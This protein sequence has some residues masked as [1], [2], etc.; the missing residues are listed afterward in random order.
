MATTKTRRKAVS[1]AALDPY[2]ETNIVSP[3]E[4]VAQGRD[5]LV[6]WGDGNVY[7]E[8]LTE[9]YDNVPTLQSIIDGTVDF[10]AGDDASILPLR[11]GMTSGA[12]NLRGDTIAEQLRDIATDLNLYGGFALQVIRGRD[13]RPSEVYYIDMRRIR[14]N[15]DNSVFWWCEDWTRRAAHETV[16]YPVYIPFLDWG[17]LDED[18]RN[19]HASSIL[20]VKSVRRK[21]YPVPKF[22]SAVKA[23]EIERGIDD[24]HL[25][26]L[27]NGF[28]SSQIVNFN[29]GD[30]GDQM[31]EQI[32]DEF[33]EKFSGHANAGRILFSW[34]NSKDTATTIESPTV[35]DFGDRYKALSERSRQQL[36]TAFRANPNLFGIP[37]EGNGFA[38]EQYEESFR[39]YNRTAVQPMQRMICDAYDRIYGQQG[40]LTITPF[41]LERGGEKEVR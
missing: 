24:F 33:T 3:R 5:G 13:G 35:E 41:T 2:L 9:L 31:K 14:T 8:Y 7:P 21:V 25:N 23:G 19:L 4:K 27:D 10:I 16:R 40:V 34:N 37:T 28:T 6:E 32:E 17:T 12:M 39:L 26:S 38:N 20:F 30:P 22:A 36:F 11:D 15:K 18:G 29:N 1:F